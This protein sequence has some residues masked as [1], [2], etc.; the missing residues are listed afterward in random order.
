MPASEV[1]VGTRVLGC[2]G[3]EHTYLTVSSAPPGDLFDSTAFWIF[4][5]TGD[6]EVP[7]AAQIVTSQGL[8]TAFD[9]FSYRSR[10]SYGRMDGSWPHLETVSIGGTSGTLS[11]EVSTRVLERLLGMS[12]IVGE[13]DSALLRFGGWPKPMCEHLLRIIKTEG[14]ISHGVAGWSWVGRRYGESQWL[15]SATTSPEVMVEAVKCLMRPSD[16]RSDIGV[17]PDDGNWRALAIGLLTSAAV[18]FR[19]RYAPRYA[20]LNVEFD[21]GGPPSSHASVQGMLPV[22]LT[23]YRRIS[24]RE[25]G[26]YVACNTFLCAA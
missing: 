22:R 1:T 3:G 11:S 9:L 7:S 4:S 5:D 18:S 13:D 14:E 15:R 6:L 17:A 2:R 23:R 10:A 20:P 25:P 26:S 16:E 21:I 24:L 8:R 19:T 12:T